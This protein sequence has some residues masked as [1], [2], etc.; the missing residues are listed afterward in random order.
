MVSWDNFALKISTINV[1]TFNVSSLGT[2]NAKTYLKIEGVTGKKADIIFLCDVRAGDK[3][4]ELE[5]LFR[6][7]RNGNYVLYLNSTKNSRGVGIAIKRKIAHDV[8]NTVLDRRTENYL[9]LDIELKGHRV[10][11]GCLYGPNES[12]VDFFRE[13]KTHVES[14]PNELILGGDFNTIL[15]MD[16]TVQNL[17]RI[18]RGRTPNRPN[19]VFINSWISEGRVV[20][21]F[22]ALY[23]EE[24][25]IS[26]MSYRGGLGGRHDG[27]L[28]YSKT[29]LDFFVV[30]KEILG[31]TKS[32]KYEDRLGM[33]FDHKEVILTIG[34]SV[35]PGKITV[36]DDTL[37]DEVVN[38][39]GPLAIY[40]MLSEH[41]QD[42]DERVVRDIAQL[43]ILIR[44]MELNRILLRVRGWDR[45][46]IDRITDG[47][48]NARLIIRRLG[49]HNLL[50]RRFSC[51]Y[52]RLYE[53]CMVQLK[54]KLMEVQG[55][56][57]LDKSRAREYLLSKCDEA[58]DNFGENRSK[59][60]T[61]MKDC[62]DLMMLS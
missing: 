44:G 33:D 16:V 62:K 31:I 37:R 13:V 17:D 21:P 24:R 54:N 58:R 52:R 27:N 59:Y 47:E 38:Y 9:L 10:T 32:V 43:D 3:G 8:K 25:E 14:W 57:K 20:E 7:T 39:V 5:K 42:R 56:I 11:L 22:R 6:L 18:G 41:L 48:A 29:R 12:N 28:T 40:E 23:P 15:D 34:R 55:R 19:G 61:A 35:Q 51:D 2:R 53:V 49:D 1:N 45:E 4:K 30:S 26:Y 50:L 36:F 46:I 60:G